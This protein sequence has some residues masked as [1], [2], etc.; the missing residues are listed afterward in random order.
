[1]DK[2]RNFF[3]AAPLP[4]Y[5][6]PSRKTSADIINEARLAIRESQMPQDNSFAATS[7]KP[8]QTKRPFTPR[9]KE[10]LLFGKKIKDR[11]PSS[12]S[13]RYLQTDFS[14]PPSTPEDGATRKRSETRQQRSNS[15]SEISADGKIF[16]LSVKESAAQKI[17]LPSLDLRLSHQKKKYKNAYSL[18]NLPEENEATSPRGVQTRNAFSSPQERTES[19]VSSSHSHFGRPSKKIQNLS[20]CL[21]LGP[22]NLDRIFENRHIV[23]HSDN[24]FSQSEGGAAMTIEGVL[25]L[26]AEERDE[27]VVIRLL[28]DLYECMERDGLL[29]A[30]KVASKMKIQILKT[31]YRHVESPNEVLL[32]NIAR[33]ILALKVMGNNLTGVCK[34]IFK[35]SKSDKNDNLF[36][37]KNL[38]ELFVDALGRSSPLDDAEACVYGYGSIKFLTMNAKL[39]HQILSLGILPLMVLHIKL[40]NNAKLENIFIPDQTNHAVFQLTG[41]LRNLASDETMYENFVETQAIQQLCQTLDLFT[42]NADI[43]SNISRTLSI[44][45]TNEGCCDA[46]SEYPGIYRL[47]IRMFKKYPENDEIIVRLT[48]TLGNVVANL[49][50]ARNK[51]YNEDES[52]KTLLLLWRIYLERTLKFCSLNDDGKSSTATEDVMIKIIRIVANM[53]INPDIGKAMNENFGAQF[54]DEFIKVLISNPFKKN[55]ELVLSVLSTLNNLSFYYS[56]ELNE[57]IFHVKQINIIEAISEYTCC[58]SKECLIEAMRILGNLSRSKI[59]R[60]FI[61]ETNIFS[62]LISMLDSGDL[63][64]LKTTVGVFVNLMADQKNRKLLLENYGL[65]KLIGVMNNYGQYDWSLSMLV[66]QVI[67]NY[68]I[69]SS[70]LYEAISDVEIQQLIAILVDYLDEEKI[71]GLMD[72][73]GDN[74]DMLMTNEYMVWEEFANVATN[75]LEKVEQFLDRVDSEEAGTQSK[76][77]TVDSA[78]NIS[79]AGWE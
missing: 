61:S 35:V 40:V 46:I 18:D 66:C 44:I 75:L 17:R 20:Q 48:Y 23:E 36:F 77:S 8:L 49:D 47:F 22:Q 26:L 34:L 6:P 29:V 39:L 32:L 68:C 2:N 54:I 19:A 42:L 43:V 33:I 10:R 13:L 16:N 27:T 21:L 53:A 60:S 67:W 45:S 58:E 3:G 78:T 1:M 4:F 14:V 12:F 59:T 64:L 65:L 73:T 28:D 76:R 70:N 25:A 52:I 72:S 51:Y 62:T 55:E 74:S 69:D 63:S 24:L 41:A 5:E 71:F 57:D 30:S 15:L 56:A 11:P 37:K 9:D 79:F 50:N 38:L 7:I 31:L